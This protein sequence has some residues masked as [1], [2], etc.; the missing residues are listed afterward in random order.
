MKVAAGQA[1]TTRP[2]S[3]GPGSSDYIYLYDKAKLIALATEDQ[4]PLL[5]HSISCGLGKRGVNSLRRG[6]Q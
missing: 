6:G 2:I 3:G 5:S 1:L 4:L